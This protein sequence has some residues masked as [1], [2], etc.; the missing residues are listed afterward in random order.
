MKL[1]LVTLL[2][3][4]STLSMQAQQDSI[5]LWP[6]KVP[7][8]KKAKKPAV[9]S[10]RSNGNTMRISEV[11]NPQILVFE[12]KKENKTGIG[13]IVSPGGGY[14]ILA[15]DKEGTEVAEWLNTLGYTAF[16]LQYRVPQNRE[17]ALADVQRAIRLVK[18]KATD[19]NLDTDKIGVMGF[20]AGGS[21]SARAA[22][23]FNEQVYTSVDALDTL[24]ARPAFAGLIYPAYLDEGYNR[25]LTPEL[26]LSHN[27]PPFFI[28]GTADDPYGNSCLVMTTALRDRKLPVELHYLAR[29]GHGYGLRKG[30]NAAETWPELMAIWLKK[31]E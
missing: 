1:I 26:T 28:F 16:V 23:R 5:Y 20:S 17:A 19:Y 9:I 11:T 15:F 2:A 12:P 10:T 3:F 27:T 14:S 22:T 7:F 24:S 6:G 21:L 8:E 18:S 30:S 4:V 29:G 31:F 25:A 13:V